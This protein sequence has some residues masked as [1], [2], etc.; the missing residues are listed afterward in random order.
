MLVRVVRSDYS[1]LSSFLLGPKDSKLKVG[2][3]ISLWD[4]VSVWG[5]E[6]LLY[7]WCE[8]TGIRFIWKPLRT[9]VYATIVQVAC[10]DIDIRD[11]HSEGLLVDHLGLKSQYTNS[12]SGLFIMKYPMQ[13][14]YVANPRDFMAWCGRKVPLVC[15]ILGQLVR[16]FV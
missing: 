5:W 6:T 12:S 8:E 10:D 14:L 3:V 7:C 15:H 16:M 2:N 4:L 11:F 1:N 9:N 13:G